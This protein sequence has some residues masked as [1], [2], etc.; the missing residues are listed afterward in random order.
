MNELE[1]YTIRKRIMELENE[2]AGQARALRHLERDIKCDSCLRTRNTVPMGA[3]PTECYE[4][5]DEII[6]IG[7]PLDDHDCDVMGCS[8]VSH[9]RYRFKKEDL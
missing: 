5:E 9:V 2:N 3:T 8:S 6:I 1:A 4:T 7:D